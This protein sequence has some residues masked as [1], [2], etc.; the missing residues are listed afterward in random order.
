[1]TQAKLLAQHRLFNR[2][3]WVG[4]GLFVV[5]LP[6]LPTTLFAATQGA[7]GW[8]FVLPAIG[9][10]GLSLGA[11]GT[12]N[13]TALHAA[14]AAA[15]V[16]TL[17][18]DVAAELAHEERV[19]PARLLAIHH[20]PKASLLIPVIAAGLIAYMANQLAGALAT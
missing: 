4:I 18:A 13:D 8:L 19:R 1:M 6:V 11:F 2:V 17:P 5:A 16:G 20:S 10:L 7:V 12:A 14:R 3:R 15:Q 9:C